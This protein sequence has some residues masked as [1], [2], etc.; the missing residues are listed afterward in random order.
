MTAR[1]SYVVEIDA[2]A[3]RDIRALARN[4]QIRILAKV[5]A[6]SAD[7]RPPGSVKLAGQSALW[8]IRLGDYRIIYQIQDLRLVV[9]VVKVG[10]RR[11]V[12]RGL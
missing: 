7:P 2:K 11:D 9:T 6:L 1:P 10:H 4:D 5:M 3:T 8:R 12:Y